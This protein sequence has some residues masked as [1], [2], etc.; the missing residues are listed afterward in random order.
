MRIYQKKV[1]YLG[2][3]TGFYILWFLFKL[4]GIPDLKQAVSSTAIDVTVSLLCL[5]IS[6]EYLL[7]R[8]VYKKKYGHFILLTGSM[9]LIAGSI[10]V[11]SQL[12]LMGSSVFAYRRNIAKYQ[13][14]FFY[15]FWSDLIFGSYFLIT[16]ISLAGCAIRLVFDRI[17]VEK[18][19][20]TLEKQ[21][22]FSELMMLKHQIN[23]H[24]LFNALNTVY[25]KIDKSNLTARKILEQFSSLLRYQLYE[26]NMPTVLVENELEFLK[27][28]IEVQAQRLNG[29]VKIICRGFTEVKG[30]QISPYLLVPLV[31]NCFKHVSVSEQNSYILIECGL[32]GHLFWIYAENSAKKQRDKNEKGIGLTNITKRLAIIYP[33]KHN[34]QI[35]S[36]ECLFKVKLQLNVL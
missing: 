5:Y 20:E 28:Y 14:H 21:K 24:F 25:Y 16:F 30:F 15:W 4:G 35:D 3:A 9:V 26:C 31:E 13:E 34:L 18:R 22:I 7:P 32:D 29:G 36:E 12:K 11:L 1:Y 33:Q 10:I 6:V 2:F 17:A 23:P 27:N 19:V 8:Y